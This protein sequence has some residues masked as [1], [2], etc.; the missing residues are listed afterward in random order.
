MEAGGELGVR[1]RGSGVGRSGEERRSVAGATR[2]EFVG[3]GAEISGTGPIGKVE[4]PLFSFAH[5]CQSLK[6]SHTNSLASGQL[7]I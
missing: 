5:G 1:G 7:W 6:Q 2:F 4:C 3:V